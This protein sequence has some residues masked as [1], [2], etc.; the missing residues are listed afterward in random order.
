MIQG[1]GGFSPPLLDH[2]ALRLWMLEHEPQPLEL[3][4]EPPKLKPPGA[5]A[6][7]SEVRELEL[8]ELKL[9]PVGLKPQPPQE[10]GAKAPHARQFGT[11]TADDRT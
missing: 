7:V 6:S 5:E 8:L 11:S 4:P 2:L 10:R 9:K 1:M 3:K